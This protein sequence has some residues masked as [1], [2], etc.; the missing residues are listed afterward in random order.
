MFVIRG[1]ET[2]A[3][4]AHARIKEHVTHGQLAELLQMLEAIGIVKVEPEA[5]AQP[6]AAPKPEPVIQAAAA[7]PAS[8]ASP[9]APAAEVPAGTA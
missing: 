9:A 1:I 2:A 5:Q 7:E 4:A 8:A 6:V 3:A